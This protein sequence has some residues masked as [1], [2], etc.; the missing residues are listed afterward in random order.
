MREAFRI[1]QVGVE[2][3]RTPLP[4]LERLHA[5]RRELLPPFDL[6]RPGLV[7]VA[8][9]HRLE[10]YTEGADTASAVGTWQ[11]WL[12]L[13]TSELDA[14]STSLAIREN[15]DAARHLLRV[16]AGLESAVLGED[17]IQGQVRE[18]YRRACANREPGALL[19]RLFHAA[20]R[21]GKRVRTETPLKE[22]GRSLAGCAV[23]WLSR[24]LGGIAGKAVLVLGAGEMGS[25]AARKL[26]ERGARRLLVTNR[27]WSRGAALAEQVGA[28]A[29][30]WPWRRA[31]L[32]EVAGV[33]SACHAPEPVIPGEWL[34]AAALP[35]RRLAVVD[36][37]MPRSVEPPAALPPG[38]VLA[39]LATLTA[40]MEGEAERRRAAVGDA[41][42][43]V[44]E[45]L[46]E[47]L[48]WAEGRADGPASGRQ[49]CASGPAEK[50]FVPVT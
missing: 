43:I 46:E 44:E 9:C 47:W 18:A 36:L 14:L 16:A 8:T 32:A 29:L 17:Q 48:D 42:K 6:P 2:Q 23:G 40:A 13:S 4:V 49:A 31:A 38:L 45:E 20:F 3:R 35:S 12:G 37:A 25:I 22:G 26:R 33:I 41:E 15:A 19:H 11:T 10:L 30:P 28:E 24:R 1:V 27:T 21:A 5:R 50:H 7:R 39:D 34:A